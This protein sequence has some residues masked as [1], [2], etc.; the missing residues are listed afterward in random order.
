M[1]PQDRSFHSPQIKARVTPVWSAATCSVMACPEFL[2]SAV[3]ARVPG[4]FGA[5]RH[6]RPRLLGAGGI[7]YT[8]APSALAPG[9]LASSQGRRRGETTAIG[10]RL[11][12][13]TRSDLVPARRLFSSPPLKAG[14]RLLATAARDRSVR[15]SARIAGDGSGAVCLLRGRPSAGYAVAATC[16]GRLDFPADAGLEHEQGADR[17]FA[18][19]VR[20]SYGVLVPWCFGR[21]EGR[22]ELVSEFIQQDRSE[23]RTRP[24]SVAALQR[25]RLFA[26]SPF[27]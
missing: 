10:D 22:Y 20:F 13:V 16:L 8:S 26:G 1:G 11:V 7:A 3:V 9:R 2:N 12:F 14:A 23:I 21:P 15:A 24:W 17:R 18:V 4:P 25:S 19:A 5:Q 6:A 27:C